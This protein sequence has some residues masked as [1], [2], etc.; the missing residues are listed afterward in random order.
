MR[1]LCIALI[2]AGAALAD[3]PAVAP[4]YVAPAA[5]AADRYGS[6]AARSPAPAADSYGSPQAAPAAAADSY[7]SPQAAPQTDSYGSPAAPVVA[8]NDEYGSPA[9][10]VQQNY[11]AEPAAAAAPA[12]NQGY[13]Y[14]YYPVKQGYGGQQAAAQEPDDGGLLGRISGALGTKVLLLALGITGLLVIAALGV[15]FGGGRAFSSTARALK[16]SVAKMAEP[17]LTEEAMFESLD[18]LHK[19]WATYESL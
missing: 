6:P 12:G 15:N 4:A 5:A 19:A 10:P 2:F 7:G 8:N 14:Y 17:Y 9:A 3:K 18:F 1:V 16:E 11:N 13:Y